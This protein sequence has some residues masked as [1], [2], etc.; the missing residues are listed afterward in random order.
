MIVF[1]YAFEDSNQ[2]I[3]KEI[4]LYEI[5]HVLDLWYEFAIKPD[6]CGHGPEGFGAK[7]FL[8]ENPNLVMSYEFPPRSRTAIARK[9]LSSTSCLMDIWLAAVLLRTIS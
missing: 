4:F 3:L 7:K 5:G 9:L 6:R 2:S 8:Q 1:S